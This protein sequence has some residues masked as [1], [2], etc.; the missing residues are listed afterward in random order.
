MRRATN[1]DFA[2]GS[3]V[4]AQD[5]G[6]SSAVLGETPMPRDPMNHGAGRATAHSLLQAA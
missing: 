2:W 6:R 4:F 1:P 3:R 5:T